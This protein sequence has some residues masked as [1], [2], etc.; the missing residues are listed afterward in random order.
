VAPATAAGDEENR[1]GQR[2]QSGDTAQI[3]SQNWAIILTKEGSVRL[4]D[5]SYCL[6]RN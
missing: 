6:V 1:C 5:L 4:L 2:K 3:S